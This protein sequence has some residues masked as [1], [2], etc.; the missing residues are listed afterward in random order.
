M[1]KPKLLVVSRPDHYALRNLDAIRDQA[2][3][4][5]SDQVCEIAEHGPEAEIVLYPG[6]AGAPSLKTIWPHLKRVRWI[7]SLA[8]GVE[9][10]LFPELIESPVPLT[11][12]RGVF[13][14]SLAEFAVLGVL[15]FYKRLRRMLVSQAARHWD[16]FNV[17]LAEGKIAGIVGYGEIGR[18]CALLLKAL[19]M[20]IYATRRRPEKSAGDP[21]LDRAFAATDL[22]SM[23]RECDVVVVAAPQTPETYHLLSDPEFTAVKPNCIVINVGRGVVIDEGALIRALESGH[24]GGAALDVF[25]TEPLPTDSTLWKLENVLLSP[26]CTDRTQNPDWLDL[27]AQFFVRNFQHYVNNEELENVVDKRA[28]Y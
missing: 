8:A 7:H 20:K 23:L 5:V 1:N 11:N 6:F 2:D 10:V 4:F 13:K 17:D 12:A 26:H 14:R 19:G 24:I 9:K 27:S 15:F 21:I 25:E 18:E 16:N 3:V 28:G 22:L